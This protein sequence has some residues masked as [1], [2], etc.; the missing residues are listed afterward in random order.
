MSC[1][2]PPNFLL[3]KQKSLVCESACESV[4]Q[5]AVIG[6][7]ERRIRLQKQYSVDHGRDAS[8]HRSANNHSSGSNQ[9]KNGNSGNNPW[10]CNNATPEAS[11]RIF[12][13]IKNKTQSHGGE[14]NEECVILIL[15]HFSV[16][17]VMLAAI[18][19][20]RYFFSEL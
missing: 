7:H 18:F 1:A 4:C 8:T 10:G 14:S 11:L 16:V 2:R 9:Q 20:F 5:T 15:V 13:A 3:R 17:F 6:T 19:C 12:N